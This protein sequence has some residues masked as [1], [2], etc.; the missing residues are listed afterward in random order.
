[1]TFNASD[2][3]LYTCQSL[4]YTQLISACKKAN[5]RIEGREQIDP[6]IAH[7]DT[8]MDPEDLVYDILQGMGDKN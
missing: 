1:V 3:L 7:Q 2:S 8:F 6:V 4:F 5:R